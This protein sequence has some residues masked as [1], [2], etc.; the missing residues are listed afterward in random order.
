MTTKNYPK[1]IFVIT[2]VLGFESTKSLSI[3]HKID[4][5]N[6]FTNYKLI[7]I[8]STIS[9]FTLYSQE[10]NRSYHLGLK[11]HKYTTKLFG[12]YC[13][14]IAKIRVTQIQTKCYYCS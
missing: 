8:Y 9:M 10:Y 12:Y 3:Y 4:Y 11:G 2:S 5:Q 6:L 7:Y 13:M 1:L 14:A